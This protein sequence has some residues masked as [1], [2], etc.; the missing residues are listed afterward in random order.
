M[1][2]T[3]VS[4]AGIQLYPMMDTAVSKTPPSK[5]KL[6]FL[7]NHVQKLTETLFE[8]SVESPVGEISKPLDDIYLKHTFLFVTFLR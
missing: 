6:S 4:P 5:K 8:Q 7:L 1:P 3:A 2:D